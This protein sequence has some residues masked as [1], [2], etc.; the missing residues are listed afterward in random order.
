MI[1]NGYATLAEA[2]AWGRITTTDSTDDGVIEQLVESASRYID[3]EAQRVFYATTET[4]LFD[5]P[6][7]PAG[8]I[9]F[10]KD[11]LTVTTLTNGDGSTVASTAYV[12]LP[13]NYSPKFAL[14]L[15]PST[16]TIWKSAA[17]GNTLQCIS[18]AG[19]WGES[20]PADIREACLMIFKA[21]YNRR[22]GENM[23]SITTITQAGLVVTPED[24]PAKA[25]QIIHNNRR[26]A[27]A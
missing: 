4:R 26:I 25:L 22:F 12:L 8:V 9:M 10:D 23:S 11:L 24:V 7:N 27:F 3:T 6:N 1:T 2:K 16:S 21:A 18:I 15:I 19:S 14:Q 20:C 5:M 17:N 13:A